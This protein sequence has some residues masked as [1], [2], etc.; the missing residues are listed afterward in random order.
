MLRIASTQCI[1]SNLADTGENVVVWVIVRVC[2]VVLRRTVVGVRLSKRQ[3]TPT[4]VLLRTTLQT[5]TITQ[6]TTLTH[7]GSNLSLLYRR[8]HW[9]REGMPSWIII[10]TWS[11]R[12]LASTPVES[13]D[14]GDNTGHEKGRHLE[15]S[16]AHDL[17]EVWLRRVYYRADT[18]ENTGQEK[19]RHLESS[20]AHDLAE[21]WLW[22]VYY[23][24]ERRLGVSLSVSSFSL[25][26]IVF[27]TD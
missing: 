16:I 13:G 23:R 3:S 18:G 19:G 21:V 12:S 22:R 4:T 15:S 26:T 5:R 1:V 11:R 7:L 8:E 9:A 14:T 20:I 27:I 17:A 24:T 10:R 25:D 6:T 2:S